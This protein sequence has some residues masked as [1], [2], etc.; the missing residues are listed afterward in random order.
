[1]GICLIHR[2]AALEEYLADLDEIKIDLD[3]TKFKS[4]KIT[5]RYVECTELYRVSVE[6]EDQDDIIQAIC[7][8]PHDYGEFCKHQ[9]AVF[10]TLR[11]DQDEDKPVE[12]SSGTERRAASTI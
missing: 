8:C 10:Y 4:D 12:K 5:R 3:R 2:S 6:L 1:M 9:V 7:D 11:N